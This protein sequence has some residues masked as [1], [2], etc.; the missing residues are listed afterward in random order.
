MILRYLDR[1]KVGRCQSNFKGR[2]NPLP[3]FFARKIPPP[4]NPLTGLARSQAAFLK[5]TFEGK[6]RINGVPIG[7]PL[8]ALRINN[9]FFDENPE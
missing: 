9:P 6:G 8:D 7:M 2:Q 3:A 1:G 5:D 4:Q